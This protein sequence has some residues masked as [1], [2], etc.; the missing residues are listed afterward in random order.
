MSDYS[1]PGLYE[2]IPQHAQKMSLNVW[3]GGSSAK[4][5]I[6]DRE[7][8]IIAGNSGLYLAYDD[9][10]KVTVQLRA[11]LDTSIRW[12]LAYAG[13]GAFCVNG[14]KQ[15]NVRGGGKE[16]GTEVI[17]Y[18]LSATSENAQFILKAVV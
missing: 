17:T 16:N 7:Y 14:K 13:N 15:L 12:K 2:I 18:D 5:E 6:G 3:A 1:G 9:A 4:P 10:G 8:H 11:P